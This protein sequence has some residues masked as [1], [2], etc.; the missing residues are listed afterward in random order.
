[1]PFHLIIHG[2]LED[3]E[4]LGLGAICQLLVNGREVVFMCDI[5]DKQKD[6]DTPCAYETGK[7]FL[8]GSEANLLSSFALGSIVLDQNPQL[9]GNLILLKWTAQP[10]RG[11]SPAQGCE[12]GAGCVMA[13]TG[14][15]LAV[16]QV[17][18]ALKK[19]MR[20][21]HSTVRLSATI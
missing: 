2:K 4:L 12:G 6:D 21:W 15:V 19:L 1:M 18:A 17:M 3:G 14:K 20:G 16:V 9:G 13:R 7:G 5:A 11:G 8:L 10:P